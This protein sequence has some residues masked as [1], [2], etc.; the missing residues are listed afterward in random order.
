MG[1]QLVAAHYKKQQQMVPT[2]PPAKPRPPK[3]PVF[4]AQLKKDQSDLI[5]NPDIKTPFNAFRDI[6][7]RLAKYHVY[8]SYEPSPEHE[9][10]IEEVFESVSDN[11]LTKAENMMERYRYVAMRG[12]MREYSASESVM[13][14]RMW[15]EK[16]K[17][18]LKDDREAVDK[19]PASYYESI[20]KTSWEK[21]KQT[22]ASED[23]A[24]KIDDHTK[25]QS[26]EDDVIMLKYEGEDAEEMEKL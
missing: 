19:N 14:Q 13:L 11:L 12:S 25:D 2:P 8:Q 24:E 21:F 18:E 26:D 3:P 6:A 20:P 15:I 16:E 17:R 9:A 10:A 23:A 4:S 22:M 5:N 1:Q 7:E